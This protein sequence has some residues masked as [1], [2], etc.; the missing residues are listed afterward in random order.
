MFL[1]IILPRITYA[2]SIN[3]GKELLRKIKVE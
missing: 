1:N 2:G 3:L